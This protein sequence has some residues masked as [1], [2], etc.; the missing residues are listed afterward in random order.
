M[1]GDYPIIEINGFHKKLNVL[2]AFQV[3]MSTVADLK[4]TCLKYFTKMDNSDMW[5][6]KCGK[7]LK[8]KQG[9]GWS[10]LTVHIRTQHEN[11]TPKSN[12]GTLDF[13]HCRKSENI[14]GWI[15]WVCMDLKPF[16]FVENELTRKYSCLEKI[17]I[18]TLEKYM[19][20]LTNEVEKVHARELPDKIAL[21]IDGWIRGSTHF[22]GVVACY[23]SHDQDFETALLAFS[24]LLDETSQSSS[25]QFDFLMLTLLNFGKNI[26]ENVIALVADNCETNK[27]LADLCEVPLIGCSS[28]KLALAVKELLKPHETLLNKINMIMGKLKSPKMSA[29]LRKLT[30]LRPI[31]QGATRFLS[32]MQMMERYLSIKDHLSKIPGLLELLLSPVEDNEVKEGWL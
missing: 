23:P 26:A 4:S 14:Y 8:K 16:A 25:E 9:T 12:Q 5:K 24:P 28:H 30:P 10:N 13:M 22:L 17:T 27:A 7:I 31:Q 29:E 32:T 6:G 2:L 15:E 11:S 3:E 19:H 20:L 21:M 18:T 1:I